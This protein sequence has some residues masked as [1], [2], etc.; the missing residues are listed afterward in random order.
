M[1]KLLS[2][3]LAAAVVAAMAAPAP[4][5]VPPRDCGITKIRGKRYTIKADRIT[6][7]T[8]E[9]YIINW[10]RERRRPRGWTCK[11]YSGQKLRYRC[12]DASPRR[13]AFAILRS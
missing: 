11:T 6:C 4:A 7:R 12:Y 5:V 9:R 3:L 13:E 2:L 8:A 1:K 10:V